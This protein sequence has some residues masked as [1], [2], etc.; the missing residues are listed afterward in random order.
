MFIEQRAECLGEGPEHAVVVKK[1]TE[2]L[3]FLHGQYPTGM[4]HNDVKARGN[5]KI[6]D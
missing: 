2:I 5:I 3:S 1:L 6:A 4:V